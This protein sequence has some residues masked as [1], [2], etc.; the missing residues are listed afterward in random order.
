MS[1]NKKLSIRIGRIT[2][3]TYFR[4]GRITRVKN[5]SESKNRN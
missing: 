3:V 4:I 5:G 1:K 2:K